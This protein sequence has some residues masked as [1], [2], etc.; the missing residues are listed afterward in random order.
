MLIVSFL[1][2]FVL[3]GFFWPQHV[4]CGILAPR[5]LSSLT[6]DRTH[7]LC[8]GAQS[9]KHWAMGEIF[10]FFFFFKHLSLI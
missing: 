3:W 6:K 1:I 4:A 2:Y 9:L 8:S 7:A 5:H 10:C